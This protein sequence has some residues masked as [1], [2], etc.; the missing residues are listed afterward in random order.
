MSR[1]TPRRGRSRLLPRTVRGRS[2]A[3]A[4]LAM[5]LVLA[6]GG[7]WL[8][9]ILR[10][11]LLDNANGRT[12]L[13]AREVAALA[14]A[15]PLPSLLPAPRSGVDMVLVLDPRGKVVATSRPSAEPLARAFADLRPQPG[16]DAASKV[17]CCSPAMGGER[18]DVVVVRAS[19]V[20]GEERYVY[21]LTVLND[22]DDATHAIALGLLGGAPPLIAL[23]AAIAWA[24]TGLALRPVTAIR[25]ELA[26]VTASELGRRVPD[27]AGGDEVAALARTVNAT[28][29]RLEQAVARQRQFVADASHELR[30]PVA[31]VRSQLEVA[32]AA[33]ARPGHRADCATDCPTDG[34]VECPT[35]GCPTS[36]AVRA[37]LAD[38]VRLQ[39]I[40]ADL[41]LLARLDARVPT[42]AGE[43]VDL[44]LLAAEEAARRAATRVPLT[45]TADLPAPMRG[46]TGQ[47]ERLLANLVDNA[48]RHAASQVEVRAFLDGTAGQAVLEVTDDG[49]GIAA[50]QRERVF[51]RFVRLDAARDRE[52]GGSGLG[53]AIAREIAHAHGGS[54]VVA[55]GGGGARL[56]ARFPLPDGHPGKPATARPAGS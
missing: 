54:L 38:T 17:L 28:L 19:P 34:A 16:Q 25:T 21:A 12:E 48:L 46:R 51:Q 44:A 35:A 32:L 52:S 36:G 29:D 49:P 55:A 20:P 8:Y 33:A 50:D 2:A 11:N 40:A 10:T 23:A 15:G 9:A 56:V 42:G 4:A 6:G 24:V 31:A 27:P 1:P 14:D 13:A 22:V 39:H 3:A 53:L 37:A 45:V 26:A 41:L 47:L 30:N 18:G 5:A 43:P 7:G